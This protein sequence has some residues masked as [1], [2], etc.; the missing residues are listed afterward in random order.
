VGVFVVVGQGL[1]TKAGVAHERPVVGV[2]F[3]QDVG[4]CRG[5]GGYGAAHRGE[6]CGQRGCR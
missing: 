2:V 1:R 4:V 3:H 5:C 6:R